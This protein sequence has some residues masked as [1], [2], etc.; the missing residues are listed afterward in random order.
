MASQ[1]K[2]T[3]NEVIWLSFHLNYYRD[4]SGSR[5]EPL[6]PLSLMNSLVFVYFIRLG[7]YRG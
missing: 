1:G 7:E 2:G 5:E 3:N 4:L 6:S